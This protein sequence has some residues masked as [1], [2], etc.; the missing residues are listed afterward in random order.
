MQKLIAGLITAI[1]AAALVAFVS[2]LGGTIVWMIWPTAVY[3]FPRL[4]AEGW[5]EPKLSWWTCVCLAWT[6]GILVKAT[7][8]N[9]SK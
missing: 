1:G 4:V 2:T 7:Y 6:T 3:A 9:N 5:L 8:T